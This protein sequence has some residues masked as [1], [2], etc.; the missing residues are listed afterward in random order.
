MSLKITF[1][2]VGYGESILIRCPV[3]DEERSFTMLI[4]GGSAEK[5]EY[6]GYPHRVRAVDYLES[7]GVSKLELVVNTHVHED[8]TSGLVAV[9]ERFP[10]DE[11]WCC[12]LPKAARDWGVLPESVAT[13]TATKKSL[14]ALN[15]HRLLMQHFFRN[16]VSIRSL[17]EQERPFRLADGFTARVIGPTERNA[18]S[19]CSRLDELYHEAD[20]ETQKKLL[21]GI[22]ADMNNHSVMLML[23]YFDTRI[24]LPG[25]TNRMGY[26]HLLKRD[27]PADIFKVGHHGQR[28]GADAELLSAVSPKVVAVCASSDRRYE[29]MH[30]DILTLVSALPTKPQLV[31]SDVPNLPPWTDGVP[32]HS[33]SEITVSESGE[34]RLKYL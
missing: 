4:D 7:I 15:A 26:K 25:D 30:P 13:T 22:D 12:A 34:I 5:E 17:Y 28:D 16:G 1:I 3:A 29:S 24:L 27:L 6:A 14:A 19:M 32:E 23:E 9:A 18:L 20:A 33:A 2:N 21:T 11:Y 31:L 10:I 8:H